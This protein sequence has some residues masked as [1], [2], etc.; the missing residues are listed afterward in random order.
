MPMRSGP[1]RSEV[2]DGNG[3]TLKQMED[4]EEWCEAVSEFWWNNVDNV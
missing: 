1:E 2:H 4:D 3:R